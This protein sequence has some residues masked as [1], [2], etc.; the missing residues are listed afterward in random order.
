M[1]IRKAQREDGKAIADCLFLAMEDIVYQFIGERDFEK[2]RSFLNHFTERENNQYSYQNCWV[3]EIETKVVAAVNVYDG[4]ELLKLREPVLNLFKT[5]FGRDLLIEEETQPGEFYIDSLGV[6][7]DH[8]GKGI[9]SKMLNFLIDEY[10]MNHH[11][12]LG[13][14][15]EEKN[16]KA[17]KL[18][19]KLGFQ[20]VGEKTLLGKKMKHLQ[21]RSLL[22]SAGPTGPASSHRDS[23][24]LHH[25]Q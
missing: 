22:S 2:A 14:L 9:G 25:E 4:A 10:V 11:Q 15:V 23:E 16:L 12:T 3:T 24:R 1:L 13:L 17:Q 21:I 18:Y 5:E 20:P 6:H 19:L 8:Q 7:P